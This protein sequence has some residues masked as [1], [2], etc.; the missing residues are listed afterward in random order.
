MATIAAQR[1]P[2]YWQKVPGGLP[3][4]VDVSKFSGNIF[5]VDSNA[6]NA[7][8]TTGHGSEPDAPFATWDYAVGQC[9]A[10]QGDVILILPGHA[11]AVIAAGTVTLDVAGVTTI[12]L[13]HGAAR[14]TM[15]FGTAVGASVLIT[16]ANVKVLNALC[17]AA[18]DGLTNPWHVQA[19]DCELDLEWRDGS[20][21]IEAERAVL[22]TAA[23]DRLKVNLVHRGFITGNAGVNAIRLVGCDG[24][25]INVDYYGLC[26]TA[27]VEF[28][29]TACTNVDVKGRFYVH[30]QSLV[31]NV[32]DTVTGSTWTAD[33][34]DSIAGAHFSGGNA[35]ALAADD[36]SAVKAETAL[37]KTETDKIASVKTVT[38][39]L[40]YDRVLKVTIADGTTIPNNSQAAG[41]LLATATGGDCLI[42]EIVWQ[43]GATAFTVAT[44]LEFS[45]DNTNGL[46]GAAAPNVVALLAKFAANNTGIASIDGSTK[47]LPFVLESTKKLYIHGDDAA[48]GAGGATD[49]Y[50]KY[51]PLTSA[52]SLA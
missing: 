32:V 6:A 4:I 29:T 40:T 19:A 7:G 45:T 38:D 35:L 1:S 2:L 25:R 48:P 23:A 13:G 10:N 30:G 20:A 5:F 14:G 47:Q 52:G 12:F 27:V 37:I 24:A 15:T 46:T 3:A 11:E 26:T 22:T 28:L 17:V 50:I 51:R 49:F 44:N 36:V 18:I 43:R 9:T 8:D 39:A 33:G 41:G 21:T 34:F 16:A 31:R 42:E